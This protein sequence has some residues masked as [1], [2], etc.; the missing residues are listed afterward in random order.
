MQLIMIST[1]ALLFALLC[2]PT[3]ANRTARHHNGMPFADLQARLENERTYRLS[4]TR[5]W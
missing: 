1:A 2:L 4:P 5:G 3:R